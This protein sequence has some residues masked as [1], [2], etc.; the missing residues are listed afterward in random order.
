MGNLGCTQDE[1]FQGLPEVN[2]KRAR[3]RPFTR[4]T[5]GDG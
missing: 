4:R 2:F 1:D 5:K 3:S